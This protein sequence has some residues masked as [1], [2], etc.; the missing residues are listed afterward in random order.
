MHNFLIAP[1]KSH[2][3][4][5]FIQGNT[6]YHLDPVANVRSSSHVI[7]YNY[8]VNMLFLILA[9]LVSSWM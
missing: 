4:V 9:E 2:I 7:V 5:V 1:L 3:R 8:S 6:V